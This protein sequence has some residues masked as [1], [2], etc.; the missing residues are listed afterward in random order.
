MGGSILLKRNVGSTDIK[1]SMLGLGTVKFGRNIGLRYPQAFNLPSMELLD[2]LLQTAFD[3][4]INLLDTAPAYGESEERLGR[5]LLGRRHSWVLTSKAGETFIDGKSF[6]DFSPGAIV[7]SIE[8]SL[9]H[10]RTDYLDIALIHSN[11]ADEEIHTQ[12]NVFETLEALKLSGKIRAY[13]MSTKTVA[14]GMLSLKAAD[15]AMVTFNPHAQDEQKVIAYAHQMHK[16][17]F[18]KKALA[19]GH[20][21]LSCASENKPILQALRAIY[22]EPGVT[23]VVIGT[24]NPLHLKQNVAHA[25]TALSASKD[26]SLF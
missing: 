26:Q 20:L 7:R 23:S 4:G 15:L 13:G 14:G 25:L 1:V 2:N 3:L 17:I 12:F 22:Q 21:P 6:Y 9:L 24:I 10:L 5:L 18:V 16:G 11:G 8:Q 19:S